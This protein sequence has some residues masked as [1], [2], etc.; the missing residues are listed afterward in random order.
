M[1]CLRFKRKVISHLSKV[2]CLFIGS[3][4]D[5]YA[6]NQALTHVNILKVPPFFGFPCLK[7]QNAGKG[8]RPA[9]PIKQRKGTLP[10]VWWNL[11]METPAR[12]QC[13]VALH[14]YSEDQ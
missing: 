1:L 13:P 14:R 2:K 7:P 8:I 9:Y 3:L 4:R 6:E 11:S 10:Q 12:F 5:L